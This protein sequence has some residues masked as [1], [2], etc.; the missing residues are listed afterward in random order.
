MR[1][2]ALLCLLAAPAGAQSFSL[3]Q[4]CDA[5]L[6]VQSRS[7][8]VGHHFVCEGDPEGLQRRAVLGEDG[9]EFV[10]AIDAETQ[11]IESHFMT[12]GHSERLEEAPRDPA[13]FTELLETGEDTY[14]FRTIS[15]E[16]GETRYV[17]RDG[18]TGVTETIDGVTLQQTE[19]SIV[20]YGPGGEEEWRASGNEWI[21]TDFRMF[22]SGTSTITTPD[23][24]WESDE[25]PVE[26]IFPGEPGF[27]S[28]NP[29]YDC[30]AM[31][32]KLEIAK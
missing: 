20:V 13:S 19:Y 32:S 18:L 8:T 23:D 17:G 27:L 11:W 6:T 12:S 24:E 29:K 31:M 30:G 14:D 9:L 10:G 16:I 3:P 22:L 26:F 7:C 4:G 15:P 2:A 1:Y 5:F 21:S 28:S 25:S